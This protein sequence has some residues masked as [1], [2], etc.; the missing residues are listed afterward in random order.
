MN[1]VSI[2]ATLATIHF[3]ALMSPGPDFALV[4]YNSTRQGKSTGIAIA[5]GLSLGILTHSILSIAGI[6]LLVHQHPL[7]F[8]VIQILGGSYL[9]YLGYGA[10]ASVYSRQKQQNESSASHEQ[11]TIRLNSHSEAISRGFLTNILN[12]KALVFFISLMSTLVPVG[13]SLEGK[14]MALFILWSLAFI[15]FALL[16]WLLSTRK[17]QNLIQSAAK[18][19]DGICGLIFSLIGI[20]ILFTSITKLI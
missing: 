19:I 6:S 12:P 18:Y 1:E 10:L 13:M 7:W 3:I 8:A 11:K 20:T 17:M 2:L 15:W 4:V 16:A 5:F 14:L 9:L